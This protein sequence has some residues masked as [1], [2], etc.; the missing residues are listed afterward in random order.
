MLVGSKLAPPWGSQVG[1][2]KFFFSET[3]RIRAM[4][5]GIMHLFVDL[6]QFYSYDSFGV[7][8]DPNLGV[9]SWNIGTK[10]TN[11]KILLL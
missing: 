6:Y 2:S 1:T 5:F 7:K 4:I 10:K 11:F 8:T 3:V 9:T